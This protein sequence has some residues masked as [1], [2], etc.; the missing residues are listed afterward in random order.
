MTRHHFTPSDP[1]TALV[2]ADYNLLSFLSRFSLPLGFGNKTIRELCA[3]QGISADAFLLVVNFALSGTVDRGQLARVTPDEIASFLRASH[4]YYLSYR[5]PHIRANLLAAFDPAHADINPIILNYFDRYIRRVEAHFRHEEEEV[6]PYIAALSGGHLD[7]DFDI[8][9]FATSH[10]HDVEDSLEE[11]KNIILRYY[12]TGIPYRMY[13]VLIDIFNTE[14]DLTL[15]TR[16]EE[17]LLVPKTAELEAELKN[18]A[19]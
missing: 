14:D 17:E 13:D 12:T 10:D 2:D 19:K 7:P 8:A 4:D 5:F 9:R 1:V 6:F 3:E 15:H 11:M 16:I 18:S